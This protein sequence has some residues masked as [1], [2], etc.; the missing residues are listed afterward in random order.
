MK[1]QT[2]KSLN[3]YIKDISL[4]AKKMFYFAKASKYLQFF[5]NPNYYG[6]MLIKK[7]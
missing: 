2:F 7:K 3:K 4:T 5:S 1:G 6:L